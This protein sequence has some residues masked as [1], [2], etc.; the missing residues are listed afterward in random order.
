MLLDNL[1]MEFLGTF[2]LVYFTGLNLIMLKIEHVSLLAVAIANFVVYSILLWVGK[3]ISGS[4]YNPVL[5][6]CLMISKHVQVLKGIAFIF[7]QIVASIFAICLLKISLSF[8]DIQELKLETIV[9]YPL[10]VTNPIQAMI[11]EAIGTFFLVLAYYTLLLE[12]KAPKYVYGAGIGA[13]FL[14]T[15][16][17]LYDKTGCSLNPARSLAYSLIGNNYNNLYVYFIGPIVGGILGSLLGNLL[18]SE[19]ADTLRQ[20]RRTE[21]V[22]RQMSLSKKRIN[23]NI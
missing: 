8:D 4:Q 1:K 5:T 19:K 13:V 11:L 22:K 10:L 20:R 16:L 12:Q 17:S 2:M 14:A 21:K 18:L 9:G 23:E 15:T 6:I 3:A 7:C